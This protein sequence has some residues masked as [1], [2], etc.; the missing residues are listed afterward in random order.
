M[1]IEKLQKVA[2]AHVDSHFKAKWLR[3]WNSPP[4]VKNKN[5]FPSDLPL[6]E[7]VLDIWLNKASL[8]AQV[9]PHYF[10]SVSFL[11]VYMS[12]L[13]ICPSW[14]MLMLILI[15]GQVEVLDF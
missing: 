5:R 12:K 8:W 14:V 10:Y 15:S 4:D 3:W 9:H 1:T 7:K 2:T 6:R 11:P 13:N